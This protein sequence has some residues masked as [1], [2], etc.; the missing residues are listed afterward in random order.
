MSR[1]KDRRKAH[2][3]RDTAREDLCAVRAMAEAG[4]HARDCF[5]AQHAAEKAVKAAWCLLGEAPWGACRTKTGGGFPAQG[6]VAFG[7]VIGCGSCIGPVICAYAVSQWSAGS[8]AG[9]ELFRG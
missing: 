9:T 3:W 5:T 2:R 6:A 4:F 7:E 1:S 8:H